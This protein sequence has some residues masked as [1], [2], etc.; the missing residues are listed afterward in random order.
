MYIWRKLVATSRSLS[1]IFCWDQRTSIYENGYF[2]WRSFFQ[3]W[4][5]KTMAIR[6]ELGTSQYYNDINEKLY[7]VVLKV[8]DCEDHHLKN[9]KYAV[10]SW[11]K[12]R[13]F[14]INRDNIGR[15]IMFKNTI[16]RRSDCAH[17][18]KTLDMY[19]SRIYVFMISVISESFDFGKILKADYPSCFKA[20]IRVKLSINTLKFVI[21]AG[22]RM[23]WIR[24]N[25]SLDTMMYWIVHV[26]KYLYALNRTHLARGNL[27]EYHRR[28]SDLRLVISCLW[29]CVK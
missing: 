27:N 28:L 11:N 14:T 19:T 2:H 15:K 3:S 1:R 21:F 17:D 7:P 5:Q 6:S 8:L 12:C 16:T 18:F 26:T 25:F 29:W 9:R 22:S 4:V 10:E 13:S 20:L 24:T 23:I